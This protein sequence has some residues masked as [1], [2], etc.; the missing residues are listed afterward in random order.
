MMQWS[1]MGE[2][3]VVKSTTKSESWRKCSKLFTQFNRV[4]SSV[5]FLNSMLSGPAATRL[6]WFQTTARWLI[7]YSSSSP[8]QA[9]LMLA[10][11]GSS[12]LKSAGA[13][14]SC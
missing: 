7:L 11:W 5:F 10:C 1:N 3:E 8:I 14:S 6:E 2:M 12:G 4:A 9:S 13:E